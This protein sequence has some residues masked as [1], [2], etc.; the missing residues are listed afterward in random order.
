MASIPLRYRL[1]NPPALF[2]GRADEVAW[3]ADAVRRAPVTVV[4]GPAGLGKTALVLY[5]LHRRFKKKLPKTLFVSLGPTASGEDVGQEVLRALAEA[6]K[7]P[8][9]DWASLSGDPDATAESLLDLAETGSWW[10]VLDDVHHAAP[11]EARRL[12][13]QLSRYARQSKWIATSRM[14]PRIDDAVQVLTLGGMAKGDLERLA[15][16]WSQDVTGTVLARALPASGGSPWL[17]QQCLA[18]GRSE[19]AVTR[20]T[21]LADL[22]ESSRDFLDALS[23]VMV[24]LP[25]EHV[26]WFAPS[27]A[28]A[29][30][31]ALERRGL[32]EVTPAGIRLHDVVRSVLRGPG[33]EALA[34]SW[35]E[36][37]ARALARSEDLDPILESARL[38]LELGCV[39]EV[40][41]LLSAHAG[42]MFEAGYAPRLWRL[43]EPLTDE[44]LSRWRLRC[45]AE[46]GNPTALGKV[47]EPEGPCVDDRIAWA[48]TLFIQGQLAQAEDLAAGLL[49]ETG[50]GDPEHE[51][52]AG[53][54]VAR[55]LALRGERG[56]AIRQLERLPV[57][58]PDMAA[59]RDLELA[60]CLAGT[61]QGE[62]ALRLADGLRARLG[63]L[64]SRVREEV[65]VG[66]V[67]VYR[68]QGRLGE[69]SELLRAVQATPRGGA[70]SL[71]L[72]RRARWLRAELDVAG[73]ALC[74]A[75]A[76]LAELDP[77]LRS[78]S[79]LR[80]QILATRAACRLA[81][82]EIGG[83]EAELAH[84]AREAA[85]FGARPVQLRIDAL[86]V[87]LATL[88]G[89]RTDHDVPAVETRPAE[90][91]RVRLSE[92]RVR[93]GE[94]VPEEDLR[95]VAEGIDPDLRP[96]AG[97][98][99]ARLSVMRGDADAGARRAAL[100]ARDAAATGHAVR[101]AE[102]REALCEVTLL[103]GRMEELSA[104]AEELLAVAARLGSA[105]F[106]R[107][108]RLWTQCVE[109]R[110]CW[111]T[112]EQLALDDAV[113]PVTA[114]RARL[115][116]GGEPPHDLL[117]RSL[118]ERL[119]TAPGWT[120]P[121][122]LGGAREDGWTG[123]WGLDA[124]RKVAW[125]PDGRAVD[126][127][128]RALHW[129]LLSTLAEHGGH[130]AKERLVLDVWDEPEYH[131]LRHD[132][133]LQ[134]AVRKLR[135]LL[136]D[137]P[138]SPERIV[139]TE[140]GYALTG[141]LRRA[142]R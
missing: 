116:L 7:L 35:S 137:D 10:V 102:V 87:E 120:A 59:R 115:L 64:P 132:A 82:G 54:L 18:T 61:P 46:L 86:R 53:L 122:T 50:G 55:C 25:L 104:A 51:L 39:E 4:V 110:P 119:R 13:S 112:I 62:D 45:A 129:R 21:L 76:G 78:P 73:G 106:E 72:A 68:L 6:E 34:S 69:A 56:R 19:P 84:A 127:G 31:D 117:D 83:L 42:R 44:R 17:L 60:T 121:E 130:A 49:R 135:E 57:A 52:S 118:V 85:T 108:A 91:L 30:L 93:R 141:P 65:A 98:T 37:A 124:V 131:P 36:R 139:T 2:V 23:V 20:E 33:T 5:A 38:F 81:R 24:P 71:F 27:P 128:R 80:P 94:D 11:G 101:E 92:Q 89:R 109:E 12:L 29:E 95:L 125:L 8:A 58:S 3:L 123:G 22:P 28:A 1:P 90:L 48:R 79:L 97:A 40:S 140:D 75:A 70:P 14:D 47:R 113:A 88:E 126:F 15:E 96:L 107:S 105:R 100:A 16:A 103:G 111:A 136:E 32:V 134:V 67:D 133:R 43:L 74:D 142:V 138:S 26:A 99:L 9:V 114:R 63:E 66:V 41:E 77:F